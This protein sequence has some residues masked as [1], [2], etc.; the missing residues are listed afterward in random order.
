MVSSG[1]LGNIYISSAPGSE[2]VNKLSEFGR[3]ENVLSDRAKR[4]FLQ[5]HA[6]ME[7]ARMNLTVTVRLLAH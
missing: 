1:S 3:I 7:V 4:N 6:E 2:V 5:Y